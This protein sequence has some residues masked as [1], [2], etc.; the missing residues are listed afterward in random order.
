MT[1]QLVVRGVIT[2]LLTPLTNGDQWV[3]KRALAEHVNW[4]IEQGVHGLMPCG[5]TGE[6]PLLTAIER[7][8]VLEVVVKAAAQ[9]V[10]VLAH[11]GT[12]MTRETIALAR[13]ARDCGADAVSVVTPYFFRLPDGAQIEHF[14]RVADAVPDMPVYL[15]NIP[16]NTGNYLTRAIVEAILAHCPNVAGIK[17]SSGNLATLTSFIGLRSGRFQVVCG[18]DALLLQALQA[19]AIASVSGNSNVFPEILVGLFQ[20]FWKGDSEHARRLQEQLDVARLAMGDGGSL[21]TLK[22]VAEVRVRQARQMGGVRGPLPGAYAA[23]LHDG[24]AKLRAAGLL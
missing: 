2:P 14:C 10:P 8:R 24:L 23:E 6:G 9:R 22:R 20:A 19:G 17:D 3:N 21:A 11:V 15:Y 13:H 12:A 16:Q 5:T 1:T 7:R 4:L 18:S